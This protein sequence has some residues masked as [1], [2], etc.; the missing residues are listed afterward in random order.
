MQNKRLTEIDF[1]HTTGKID[2]QLRKKFNGEY[3]YFG[4]SQVDLNK[5][6]I[7]TVTHEF[8]HIISKNVAPNSFAAEI[9]KNY[10]KEVR[11]I[12]RQYDK[13]L[14]QYSWRSQTPDPAKFNEIYLGNYASTN[15]DEFHA[16][17]FTE[18]ELNSNP[19]KYAKLI[20]ELIIKYF[21]K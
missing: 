18:F 11:K 17:A 13:E 4:K 12:K 1:G 3:N 19:S 9:E 5:N 10:W 20:G 16:E 6:D 21:K 14:R 15:M 8:A 2:R 7:A